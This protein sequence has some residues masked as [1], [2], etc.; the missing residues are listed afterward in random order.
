M[1]EWI[2]NQTMNGWLYFRTWNCSIGVTNIILFICCVKIRWSLSLE[3]IEFEATCCSL[4]EKKNAMILYLIKCWNIFIFIDCKICA[5]IWIKLHTK[6][7]EKHELVDW[8]WID[9]FFFSLIV[10]LTHKKLLLKYTPYI[11]S[12][13][14]IVGMPIDMIRRCVCI[15]CGCDG[16]VWQKHEARVKLLCGSKQSDPSYWYAFQGQKF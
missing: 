11:Y 12:R 4:W 14:C 6:I 16:S 1:V 9:W 2:P 10:D 8:I 7:Y 3:C 15:C 5:L 13:H